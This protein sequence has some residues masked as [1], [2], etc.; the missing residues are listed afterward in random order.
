MNDVY[1][2]GS[3]VLTITIVG[4]YLIIQDN[5]N[6]TLISRTRSEVEVSLAKVPIELWRVLIED[7][8]GNGG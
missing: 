3:K 2:V 8:D 6:T 4:S 5:R 1:R 7:I